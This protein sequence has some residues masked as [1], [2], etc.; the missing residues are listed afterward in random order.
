MRIGIQCG[1]VMG[2]A[3]GAILRHEIFVL[4]IGPGIDHIALVAVL[5]VLFDG[6][7]DGKVVDRP[8]KFC[9][10]YRMSKK[11]SVGALPTS[12]NRVSEIWP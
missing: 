9:R 6:E 2:L 10:G 8:V 11:T 4:V 5:A 12:A 7:E 1:I 3:I